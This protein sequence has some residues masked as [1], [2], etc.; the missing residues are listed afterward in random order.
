MKSTQN[1]DFQCKKEDN[2]VFV[3]ATMK[4]FKNRTLAP[5][6]RCLDHRLL[7]SPQRIKA[8]T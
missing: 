7:G 2:T 4:V 8:K 3:M 6:V 5:L 1:C